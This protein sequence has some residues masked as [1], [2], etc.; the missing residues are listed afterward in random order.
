MLD[1]VHRSQALEG[2][3]VLDLTRARAGPTCARQFADWGANVVKIEEVTSKGETRDGM[4]QRDFV[5][6]YGPDFQNLH[7]N[8]R[9]LTLNLKAPEG[10]AALHRMVKA[11]DVVIEN[12]RPD[13][14]Y[15]LR[16]DY[17]TLADINP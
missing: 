13:V 12:Y 15:R 9:G 5:P 6:R 1:E 10:V 2:Y 16:V 7:R 14:K 17:E 8:K 11:A 3:T 4:G